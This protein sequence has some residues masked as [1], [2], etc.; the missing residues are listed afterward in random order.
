MGSQGG[1]PG[2][3]RVTPR[4]LRGQLA[5]LGAVLWIVALVNAWTP[6]LYLRSGQVKGTDFVHVYTLGRATATGH[7]SDLL[8]A[9]ALQRIQLDAVPES[10]HAF[11]PAFYGPQVGVT[12]RPLG[13]LSYRTALIVWSIVTF[14]IYLGAVVFVVRRSRSLKQFLGLVMLAS[15]AYPPFWFL[16][17]HGQ[18]TVVAMS[19]MVGAWAMM[20][21]GHELAA[22]LCLGLMAYKPQL[23]TPVALVLLAT[24]S[25]RILLGL[26]A[27]ALLQF[28]PG[29]LLLGPR[30]PVDYLAFLVEM[31][32]NGEA[33]IA[34]PEQ[35]QG[36]RA[37]W[38][39]LVPNATAAN[40][41][42][43]VSAVAT[44]GVAARVWQRHEQASVRCAVLGL[45][46]GLA[47]PHL[48]TYDLVLL[49]PA[50]L[51]LTEWFLNR[52]DAPRLF[53]QTL[54]AG[55]AAPLLGPLLATV[56]IHAVV[57]ILLLLLVLLY[58]QAPIAPP[59]RQRA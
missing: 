19:A 40:I 31:L 1:R 15:L 13:F 2:R 3:L 36:W 12:L 58:R 9:G 54:Y 41:L 48:Y 34:T 26:A 8:D 57:P 22:G 44:A 24:A 30:V 45:V 25:W 33:P 43:A 17:Q 51:W 29:I 47:A 46:I 21:R 18:L 53:G 16:I 49:A 59:E 55:F 11:F 27:G 14:G 28:L 10:A 23:V 52:P 5:A 7:A 32:R 37:F 39:L 42:F 38:A 56:R 20:R 6:T 35:F 4:E 50:W